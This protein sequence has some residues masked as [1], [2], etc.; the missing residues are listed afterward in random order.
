MGHT[1]SATMC[2]TKRT[3][4]QQ[5]AEMLIQVIANTSMCLYFI[6]LLSAKEGQHMR[7]DNL[8]NLVA[9]L[10]FQQFREVVEVVL[11]NQFREYAAFSD[12]PGD[13]GS[14]YRLFKARTS[15]VK[16][17]IQTSV[18]KQD[19]K[20][21]L[22]SDAVKYQKLFENN[23]FHY[24]TNIKIT[25]E[26]RIDVKARLLNSSNIT[27]EFYD[28]YDI[29]S[30]LM[31]TGLHEVVLKH[32]NV[33][34]RR[35]FKYEKKDIYL[36][37]YV[38][39]SD[40]IA[41]FNVGV[42]DHQ[43]KSTLY[44]DGSISEGDLIQKVSL[45]LGYKDDVSLIS[46]RLNYLRQQKDIYTENGV[47]YLREREIGFFKSSEDVYK[48][49]KSL[50][51]SGVHDILI[52]NEVELSSERVSELADM[53]SRTVVGLLLNSVES[54][55]P[56]LCV[57]RLLSDYRGNISRLNGMLAE[58]VSD[59]TVIHDTLD[60]LTGYA[61]RNDYAIQMAASGMFYSLQK[62][63]KESLSIFIAGQASRR[64][65][66]VVDASVVIPWYCSV[67]YAEAA[68]VFRKNAFTS[69]EYFRE[70][71]GSVVVPEN[72]LEEVASHYINAFKYCGLAE[73]DHD[74]EGSK[75]GFVSFYH[76]MPEVKRPESL[77]LY[78]ERLLE[79]R[80]INIE[81]DYH[82]QKRIAIQYFARM[83]K[84]YDIIIDSSRMHNKRV[85]KDIEREIS[86][87]LRDRRIQK[88]KI[89]LDHDVDVLGVMYEE[90]MNGEYSNLMIT[91]DSV[92]IELARAIPDVGMVLK[93]AVVND[94]VLLLEGKGGGELN[95]P[96]LLKGREASR[97][98]RQVMHVIDNIITH[99]G[100]NV[101]VA[102]FNIKIKQLKDDMMRK[103]MKKGSYDNVEFEKVIEKLEE[104]YRIEKRMKEYDDIE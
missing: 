65:K 4:C 80:V 103:S 78:L 73:I 39:A 19:W 41:R 13:G 31:R 1:S 63:K 48:T 64:A 12:G 55:D 69:V 92:L 11:G 71:Y 20:S 66:V 8:A 58:G 50:Y 17:G 15:D 37:S 5:Q 95:E 34:D 72:Y 84:E 2:Q 28:K 33:E 29:A 104:E 88:P 40:D 79:G 97:I 38:A 6:K 54:V 70:S 18:Q 10:E 22:I 9:A 96:L 16:I 75:N 67:L 47:L 60:L 27:V 91:W 36:Y 87:I 26:E 98:K 76:A 23:S 49:E 14:D 86:E 100:D 90:N 51:I 35:K 24:V 61:A 59:V 25:N 3:H 30:I 42:I 56:S 45:D 52:E 74:L 83:M 57:G 68:E 94:M 81:Y 32:F 7:T 93:P 44:L 99:A 43:I 102:E 82:E 53:L 89:L 85:R 77:R 62:T 21:K 46:A 101:N